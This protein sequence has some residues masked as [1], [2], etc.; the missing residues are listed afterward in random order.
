MIVKMRPPK[1]QLWKL[2]DDLPKGLIMAE[3]GSY[4]G[5]SAEMFMAKAHKLYAID[6]WKPGYS[7]KDPASQ[8][9]MIRVEELFDARAKKLNIVKL[10][11]TM[12]DAL[13][14]LPPLD[15]IYIDGDHTY[16]AVIFDILLSLWKEIPIIAGH[17]YRFNHNKPNDVVLAV[18]M[19]FGRPDKIYADTSWI[20]YLG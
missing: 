17:D 12:L 9:D 3:V 16:K 1:N 4:A 8:S 15:M 10:K 11:G 5:E 13:D 18:N 2:I 6:P 19:I 14:E 20:K 7:D